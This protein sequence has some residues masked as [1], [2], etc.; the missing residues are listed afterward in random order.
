MSDLRERL[1]AVIQTLGA[2]VTAES[3]P[4]HIATLREVLANP[5]RLSQEAGMVSV[6]LERMELPCDCYMPP[7]YEGCFCGNYDDA[8]RQGYAQGW[9]DALEAAHGNNFVCISQ[10]RFNELLDAE[11]KLSA[12]Q[13]AHGDAGEPR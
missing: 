9:N 3:R 8:R 2:G 13:V 11:L 7:D 12:A 6:P 1:E 5:E 4:R 10:S